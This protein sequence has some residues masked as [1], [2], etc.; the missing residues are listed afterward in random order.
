MKI[1]NAPTHTHKTLWLHVHFDF[2][3]S[4][5]WLRT[6]TMAFLQYSHS[7]ESVHVA[8]DSSPP[9]SCLP[10]LLAFE[11]RIFCHVLFFCV[12][13][14]SMLIL[15]TISVG[16]IFFHVV[17]VM[18]FGIHV[19]VYT[20]GQKFFKG[21]WSLNWNIDWKMHHLL[22][23]SVEKFS[24]YTYERLCLLMMYLFERSE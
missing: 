8:A 3:Y 10:H 19:G 24:R 17:W 13:S 5:S 20:L 1:E 14:I 4:Y 9:Q 11:E 2:Y 21:N 18:V 23:P 7:Y 12:I 16:K 22:F 15:F 6:I